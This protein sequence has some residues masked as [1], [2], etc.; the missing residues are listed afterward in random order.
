MNGIDAMKKVTSKTYRLVAPGTMEV[1]NIEHDL[2]PGW[3]DIE[4]VMASVCHADDRYFAGQRRPEALKKK[5]PMAL[6]HE[7]I[8]VVKESKSAAFKVGQRVVIA[9]NIPGYVLRGETRKSQIPANYSQDA[10][11]LSSGYDGIAQSDLVHPESG[12]IPIPDNVPDEIAVLTEV[13]TIGY[14]AAS[15]VKDIL[16][17][18]NVKVALFGD[19]PVGYMAAAA[20]HFIYGIG[21]ENLTVFGAMKDRL[22]EVDFAQKEMSTEYDFDNAGEQFDVIFEATGGRFSS[23]AINEGIKVIK[24]TGSFVLMGVT[25]DLVP[26]DTRDVLEKGLTLYGTSRS[27]PADFKVVIDEMSQN[28]AYRQALRKLLPDQEMTVENVS[29]MVTA[30]NTILKEKSWHKALLKFEWK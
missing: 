17:K 27:T 11:F 24:R 23:T 8:G 15:H 19:G 6:L 13:S 26:I 3:V 9:P 25:E 21:K 5:L 22:D 20:L 16:S 12:V 1:Q 18:D 30:F 4:P 29:D 14:H 28:E 7:G 2:K 10:V